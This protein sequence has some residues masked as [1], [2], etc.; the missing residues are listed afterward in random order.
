MVDAH[1]VS[2]RSPRMPE[3][4]GP[5][6]LLGRVWEL[7]KDFWSV[8]RP[9][10]FCVLVWIAI[11]SL[12][13]IV[14][15][16]QD[17][18]LA[19]LEDT[20]AATRAGLADAAVFAALVFLWA[21]QTFYW[22]R[23]VSRLPPRPHPPYRYPPPLLSEARF[24]WWNRYL[25][26]VLGGL[27]LLSVWIALL[28]SNWGVPLGSAPP[29][30]WWVQ[31]LGITAVIAILFAA[32]WLLA[33]Y[34]RNL[35]NAVHRRTGIAAFA[36]AEHFERDIPSIALDPTLKRSAFA[37]AVVT[38]AL[39]IITGFVDFGDTRALACAVALIWIAFACWAASRI[40][41]LPRST[42][43]MLRLNMIV[44][45][46]L[47][48]VSIA[49]STPLTGWLGFLSSP[50]IIMS[51][52]AAWVFLGTFLLAVPGEL[53]R[54]P[55][56]TIVIVLAVFFSVIGWRDNHLL[57]RVDAAPAWHLTSLEQA[58]DAWWNDVGSKSPQ[59][60]PLVLVATA[61]GASRA[62]YW[63]AEVLG[64]LEAAHPGFHRQVFAI[65]SVSGGSLGAVVYRG[66]LNNLTAPGQQAATDC[67]GGTVTSKTLLLC[68]RDIID[69]DFL[70][71]AFLTGLYADLTQRFLPGALLTD[72]AAALERSWEQSWHKALP[73]APGLERPFHALWPDGA[74]SLP[75]LL[76]NGTSEK[77]GRRIITSN[78]QIDTAS[79]P[80][81]V[82]FFG[83]VI[84]E[85]NRATTD[86][87]IS[88][89]IHN[90]ARFPY[91]DAAG[92][93]TL[94]DIGVNDRIVDGGYF[95]NFG[96]ASIYDLLT[97]LNRVKK[98][99]PVKFFVLQISSDPDWRSQTQR[100]ASWQQRSPASLNI[101]AD[102]TA[103]P[104]ALFNVGNA[105][106][107]RATEVLRRLM[108]TLEPKGGYAHFTLSNDAEAMSWALSRKSLDAI[109]REWMTS[110]NGAQQRIVECFISGG[111]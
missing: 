63:T 25:P 85:D 105:L 62:A 94:P 72:R 24:E 106:G 69:N 1:L 37:L 54:L 90:S 16:S 21:F 8:L 6:S 97:A 19:L 5:L 18:L 66:L 51:V 76:I 2:D 48:V 91:I 3:H 57:R 30:S 56:T 83:K 32:Y 41:G 11:S 67:K 101:A 50:P 10:R 73:R 59:P 38:L 61:G 64:Q 80:D 79:F 65:S 110:E 88:T 9:M 96:A 78:L 84:P 43:V 35:A 53:L 20:V 100:D 28:R 55:I 86:I 36:V 49:P 89:A 108:D 104:A 34:R 58:F 111:C 39:F 52:A 107:F 40:A 74:T 103:P 47:F 102:V 13:I 92:T 71:P 68:G 82:A 17:A 22:A 45:G 46:L 31:E 109:Q 93:L 77:T 98:D 70:A 23:F 33:R 42:I 60:A 99:R 26:Y 29:L 14:P 95:E 44:F 12:I 4:R 27:V 15:Q 75:A 7:F 81:A 87:P